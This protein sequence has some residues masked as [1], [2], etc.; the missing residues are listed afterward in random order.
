MTACPVC[1]AQVDV[2]ADSRVSEILECTDCRSELEIVTV[3]PAM[4]A[5]APE[6]EEDWGE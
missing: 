5:L 3:G 1:E 4:L 2:P 6:A